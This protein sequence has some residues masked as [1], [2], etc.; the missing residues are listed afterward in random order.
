VPIGLNGQKINHLDPANLLDFTT[1]SVAKSAGIGHGIGFVFFKDDPFFFLDIDHAVVSGQWSQRAVDLC[2]YFQGCYIEQSQ[3]REGLHIIGT[4]P[5]AFPHSCEDTVYKL[6]G[7]Y[8]ESRFVALTG[9]EATGNFHHTP[10]ASIYRWLIDSYFPPKATTDLD[11]WTTEPVMLASKKSPFSRSVAVQALWN[12]DADELGRAYPDEKREFDHSSADAA[13]CQHLA[14]WTG[15]NCERIDTL[16]R[17]SDLYREK[18]EREDY[19][20][21]TIMREVGRCKNFYR[22]AGADRDEAGGSV[23]AGVQFKSIYDQ[24]GHFSGCVYVED[25]HCAFTPNGRFAMDAQNNKVTKS[26]WEAFTESQ[27]LAWPKVH[28]TC[29]RPELPPGSVFTEEGWSK[30]NI[31]VPIETPRIAGDPTPFLDLLSRMLP[32]K[33]DRDIALAYCAALVQYPGVKFQWAPL[34]QGVQGNGKSLII[35]AISKAVG[36]RYS[37]FPNAT[38]LANK[39]NEWLIN[40]LFI[41]V[42]EI[43]AGN[44]PDIIE[45]LKTMIT[46]DFLDIQ[47]KGKKQDTRD[48]RANFILNTNPKDGLRITL[49]DRRYC[50]FFTAQQTKEDL[51][52][53]GRSATVRHERRVF[54]SFIRLV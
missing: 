18:W 10:D 53:Y 30:V 43:R 9:Y 44:N 45:T 27:G 36:M 33:H 17:R 29:F 1:A 21:N 24:Q 52:R 6:G 28:T 51:Q 8:T 39:F 22:E 34:F 48:N 35:R 26:A 25:Q 5:A 7:F 31:Y 20:Q 54:S 19:R 11:H 38:D 4:A 23:T 50:V 46:E 14:F 3:S 49:A 15:G 32:A 13:L 47:G 37:H 42:Q 2:R 16:F 40:K 12:A 41:G